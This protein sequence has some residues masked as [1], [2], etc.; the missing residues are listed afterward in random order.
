MSS[1]QMTFPGGEWEPGRSR[2]NALYDSYMASARWQENRAPALERANGNCEWCGCKCDTLQVHHLTYER[3]GNE[4]PKDLVALCPPCHE[5]ADAKR[6]AAWAQQVVAWQEESEKA[7]DNARFYGWVR[8][9]GA[10]IRSRAE[11]ESLLE[12][13]WEWRAEKEA[14]GDQ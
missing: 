10:E 7:L 9:I 2:F 6:R 4:L 14:E 3:F 13:Y 5:K 12:R 11:Y 1:K 8:A